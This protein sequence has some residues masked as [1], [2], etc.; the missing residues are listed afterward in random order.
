MHRP[1]LKGL[2]VL[3]MAIALSGCA[4]IVDSGPDMIPVRSDPSGASIYVNG[5]LVGKT[6]STVTLNRAS[7]GTILIEKKGYEPI[8]IQ[9]HKTLNAW[10]IG[11]LC[12]GGIPG[13]I[14]DVA[15][16]NHQKFNSTPVMVNLT[17][18][19]ANGDRG[20]SVTLRLQPKQTDSE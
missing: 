11:N 8:T 16:N 15:T 4:T 17:P 3:V 18:V 20:Q 6:P 1:K 12:F 5:M 19:D 13:L 2:F 9:K 14:I 7:S 10:L